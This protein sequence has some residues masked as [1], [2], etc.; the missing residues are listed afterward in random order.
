[1]S[2]ESMTRVND[3][4]R[5]PSHIQSVTDTMHRWIDLSRTQGWIPTIRTTPTALT[6][7][8]LLEIYKFAFNN[9]VGIESC[10][11]LNE[12][13]AL[14]M[15]VLPVHIRKQISDELKQW[16]QKHRI[17]K[18]QIINHRDPNHAE[19][20]VL[21]D[22]VS[23]IHY[24]DESPDETYLLP[25]MMRYLKKLDQSRGN[26]VIDYLPEYEELFRSAGY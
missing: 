14:R 11:F 20:S 5:Y 19:Q 15:S 6:A 3:Y 1:M 21:Q 12:P 23:Y 9:Q 17:D 10:N 7:G 25:D 2:I 22:I 26:C 8:E 13:Q 4:V 24:L 18:S 16:V